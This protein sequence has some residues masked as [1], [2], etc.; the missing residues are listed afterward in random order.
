MADTKRITVTVP[1]GVHTKLA[2]LA[3]QEKR[4][5]QSQVEWLL[6][7]AADAYT[8]YRPLPDVPEDDE[9]VTAEDVAAIAEGQAA[10]ARGEWISDDDLARKRGW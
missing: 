1:L 9:P 8:P 7:R 3:R 6:E 5:L 4:S 2:D 10:Y